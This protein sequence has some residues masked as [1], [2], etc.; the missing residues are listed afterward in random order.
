VAFVDTLSALIM[1]HVYCI[2][3]NEHGLN[4]AILVSSGTARVESR[5]IQDKI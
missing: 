4:A 2:V 1:L 5:V 3:L